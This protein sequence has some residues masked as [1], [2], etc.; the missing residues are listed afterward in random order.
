MGQYP[1]EAFA[2]QP[3]ETQRPTKTK[4]DAASR[5]TNGS[6]FI[7]RLQVYMYSYRVNE[8]SDMDH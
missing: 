3:A 8:A 4:T 1:L 2:N 6:E 7:T 5:Q